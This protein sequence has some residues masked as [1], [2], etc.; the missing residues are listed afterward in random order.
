VGRKGQRKTTLVRG[1]LVCHR[2]EWDREQTY[3]GI[4]MLFLGRKWSC[5]KNVPDKITREVI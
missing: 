4:L 2:W 3:P 5:V 1:T